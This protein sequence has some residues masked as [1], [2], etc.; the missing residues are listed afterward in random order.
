MLQC[1]RIGVCTQATEIHTMMRNSA[2]LFQ[3]MYCSG[4]RFACARFRAYEHLQ[5]EDV[6]DDLKPHEHGRLKALSA[7]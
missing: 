7:Y 2:Y 6:P 1:E 4:N 5:P 3:E